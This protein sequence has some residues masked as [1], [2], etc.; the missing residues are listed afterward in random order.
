MNLTAFRITI[1]LG[2]SVPN[3]NSL[4]E[5]EREITGSGDEHLQY[6]HLRVN[7]FDGGASLSLVDFWKTILEQKLTSYTTTLTG[8]ETIFKFGKTMQLKHNFTVCAEVSY[9]D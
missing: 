3:K 8:R 5:P 2:N 6:Q 1:Y 9:L 7:G 4:V